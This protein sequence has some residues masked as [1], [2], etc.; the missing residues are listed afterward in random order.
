MKARKGRGLIALLAVSLLGHSPEVGAQ[1]GKIRVAYASPTVYEMPVVVAKEMGFFAKNGLDVDVV[2]ISGGT[3]SLMALIAGN[4]VINQSP[5]PEVINA[6]LGGHEVVFVAGGTTTLDYWLTSRAGIQSPAQLK[7]G[8]VAISRYGSVSDFVARFLLT[9]LG[10]TPVRDV[11]VLEI[12]DTLTR[13]SAVL[14]GRVTAT[15]INPPAAFIAFRQG[16]V[17]LGDTTSLGLVFQFTAPVTTRR[18]IRE[19]PDIIRNYVRA[20]VEA[21]HFMKT[22]KEA[23]KRLAAKYFRAKDKEAWDKA[24]DFAVSDGTMPAKQYPSLAGIKTALDMQAERDPRAHTLKPEQL[25][26]MSFIKA[27]DDGGFI[28]KLYR[29]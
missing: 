16:L 4:T 14:A 23:G 26:E 10:L 25:A 20:H 15:V 27:L 8:S 7:G 5:S 9:R 1:E 13:V 11:A 6:T 3:T 24:Y 19:R 2:F 17:S 21:V 18:F 12:G 29:R 28:D 22:E